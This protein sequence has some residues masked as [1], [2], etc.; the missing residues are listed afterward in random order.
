VEDDHSI[1]FYNKNGSDELIYELRVGLQTY[2]VIKDDVDGKPSEPIS[3]ESI[4]FS[5][6]D[7]YV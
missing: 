7:I 1:T 2:S 3:G 5:L 4:H 6:E